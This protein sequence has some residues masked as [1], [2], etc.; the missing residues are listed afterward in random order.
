MQVDIPRLYSA[1]QDTWFAVEHSLKH[2]FNEKPDHDTKFVSDYLFPH[3]SSVARFEKGVVEVMRRLWVSGT[4]D[5]SQ[6]SARYC[7]HVLVL[8]DI[9][10]WLT[11]IL[12]MVS[13]R[14]I[15]TCSCLS[16]FWCQIFHTP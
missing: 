6:S 3:M 2:V 14:C 15:Y 16:R 8:L 11:C 12:A 7:K 1:M 10:K 9:I 13:P 4:T 5:H